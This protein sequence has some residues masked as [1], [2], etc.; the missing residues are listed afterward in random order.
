LALAFYRRGRVEEDSG[1]LLFLLHGFVWF[2]EG[3]GRAV[4]SSK[5]IFSLFDFLVSAVVQVAGET[6]CDVV[7][8]LDQGKDR[9]PHEET[10]WRETQMRMA[11]SR[12]FDQNFT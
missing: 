11:A 8:N 2:I 12:E 3:E 7:D 6:Q 10:W 4:Q 5:A 1:D 9:N